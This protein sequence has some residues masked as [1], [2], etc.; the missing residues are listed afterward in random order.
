[1]ENGQE[2]RK[3]IA[4]FDGFID[5]H[6]T[7]DVHGLAAFMGRTRPDGPLVYVPD[8]EVDLNHM[9]RIEQELERRGKW[10]P[11]LEALIPKPQPIYA[12]ELEMLFGKA[13]TLW[14]LTHATAE[15]RARAAYQVISQQKEGK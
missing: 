13:N 2:I 15:Q 3:A 7:E 5:P 10:M 8:Y 11:Y 14:A 1:M 12:D 4:E 6:P 9:H